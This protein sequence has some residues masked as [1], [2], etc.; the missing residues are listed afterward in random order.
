MCAESVADAAGTFGRWYGPVAS[1]TLL[2]RIV[3]PPSMVASRWSFDAV[4]RFTPDPRRTG[5]P[6]EAAYSFR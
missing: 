6:K 3:A 5:A 4:R 1:T 2:A